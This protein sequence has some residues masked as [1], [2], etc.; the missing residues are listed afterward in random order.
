MTNFTYFKSKSS[1]VVL[2][3]DDHMYNLY[4]E[5]GRNSKWRRRNRNIRGIMETPGKD[6]IIKRMNQTMILTKKQLIIKIG[7]YNVTKSD[8]NK[9]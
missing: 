2:A 9:R 7:L 8:N 1:K 4:G 6:V 3:Y 5:E